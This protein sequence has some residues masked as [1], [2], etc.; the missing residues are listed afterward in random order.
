MVSRAGQ[1]RGGPTPNSVI[2]VADL[3]ARDAP[4]AG[5][6]AAVAVT[7]RPA[8]AARPAYG[9]PGPVIP[10]QRRSS[11]VS[12][13]R[14]PTGAGGR[15]PAG[16]GD[17]I[18]RFAS[19]AWGPQWRFVTIAAAVLVAGL[20]ANG[21]M[22]ATFSGPSRSTTAES[23][24]GGYPN[25]GGYPDEGDPNAASRTYDDNG[26]PIDSALT[27][28]FAA[29]GTG[30]LAPANTSGVGV[31]MTLAALGTAAPAT[32]TARTT[33]LRSTPVASVPVRASTPSSSGS[34][35][36]STSGKSSSGSV[37]G[38]VVRDTTSGLGDTLEDTTS[39]LGKTVDQ[40]TTGLGKTLQKTT[41]G[42]GDT[43]G[44]VTD[45]LLGGGSS[46]SKSRSSSSRSSGE[47][48]RSSSNGGLLGG[49]LGN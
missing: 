35:S 46:R 23:G 10:A 30:N 25:E 16:H 5:A 22:L 40:T 29:P 9:H 45:D 17:R 34:G 13:V 47:S 6:P 41:K 49:L 32:S 33:A 28:M 21:V 7:K 2:S 11:P 39:T 4:W 31:P 27:P 38:D 8:G 18:R 15:A 14:T 48:S 3:L 42:L 26:M 44:N 12:A 1:R 37:L 20:M 36:V 24:E 43:L 19:A